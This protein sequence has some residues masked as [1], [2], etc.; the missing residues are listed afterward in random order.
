MNKKIL[1]L[2]LICNLIFI[3]FFSVLIYKRGGFSYIKEKLFPSTSVSETINDNSKYTLHYFQRVSLFNSLP[4][5]DQDIIFIGN[6][7]VSGC[8]WAE[9]FNNPHIKDR[10]IKGDKTAGLLFRIYDILKSKP[11]K[12]F[13]MA[14]IND[15][16]SHVGVDSIMKNYSNIVQIVK[17]NS[18]E[19]QL[20]LQS[21][22]PVNDDCKSINNSDINELNIKI[23]NL[24]RANNLVYINIHSHLLDN[25]DQLNKNYSNDGIHLLAE[26]YYIWKKVLEPYIVSNP[27]PS[28]LQP[29]HHS[30][31]NN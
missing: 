24:A 17:S 3:I 12:I 30:S 18:P 27:Q 20:Y 28:V 19:T 16:S 11:K 1:I 14:G 31:N 21:I 6:S 13:L 26:G 2:S 10:S 8:E 29:P 7:I 25:S 22:L 4:S 5:S 9:I 15:I 23:K